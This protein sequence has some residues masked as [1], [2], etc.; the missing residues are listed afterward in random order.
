[1]APYRDAWRALEEHRP[2]PCET[3]V[4][5]FLGQD[6]AY[7]A[8]RTD[9]SIGTMRVRRTRGRAYLLLQLAAAV[10]E[11]LRSQHGVSSLAPEQWEEAATA[12]RKMIEA[13]ILEQCDRCVPLHL[14]ERYSEGKIIALPHVTLPA[15]SPVAGEA[16][17][18]RLA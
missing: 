14:Q 3:L 6:D 8:M 2:G 4:R 12:S 13:W 15:R 1:L 16:F 5:T 7:I 9:T 11:T 18:S 10:R 17:G